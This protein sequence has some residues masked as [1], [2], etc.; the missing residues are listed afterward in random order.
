MILVA[1]LAVGLGGL[2]VLGPL[3]YLT[4]LLGAMLTKEAWTRDGLEEIGSEFL[5]LATPSAVSMTLAL[6]VL[7]LRRP[8]PVWRRLARQP[9]LMA[10]LAL[11]VA[12]G[13]SVVFTVL[14]LIAVDGFSIEAAG[15]Q[16]A[17]T[18]SWLEVFSKVGRMLGG[19]AVAICW[20]TL[21]VG[22]RWRAEPSWIDRLG[23][24]VGVAWI[25]MG[26]AAA[27]ELRGFP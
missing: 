4:D 8:R 10:C 13:C 14:H 7:R 22:G 3:E 23:R 1:A 2:R 19:F 11:V 18:F 12:W 24:I 26:M 17:D 25:V 5:L 27:Y 15:G 9:G 6:L 21:A 20:S 16:F